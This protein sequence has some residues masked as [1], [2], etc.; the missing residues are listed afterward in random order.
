MKW[1]CC[2]AIAVLALLA[3]AG[4]GA[5]VINSGSQP[6][7]KVLSCGEADFLVSSEVDPTYTYTVTQDGVKIEEGSVTV[8]AGSKKLIISIGVRATDDSAHL[9]TVTFGGVS[10]S[11]LFVHCGPVAGAKGVMGPE[12]P[13]GPAGANGPAGASGSNGTPG[14]KGSKGEVKVFQAKKKHKRHH[15]S[16]KKKHAHFTG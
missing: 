5:A 13:A 12:G 9:M 7:A 6:E 8:N 1:T 11:A 4:A 15:T 14:E 16:T 2:A 3:P 10:I